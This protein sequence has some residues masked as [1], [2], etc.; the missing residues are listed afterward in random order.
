MNKIKPCPFCGGKP[1]LWERKRGLCK[2]TI[3]CDNETCFVWIPKDVRLRE[4]HNYATCYRIKQDAID[5]WNKRR[6]DK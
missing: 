3:G 1:R 4:L 2:Y 6:N 5:A